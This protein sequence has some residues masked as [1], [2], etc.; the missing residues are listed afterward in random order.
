[1]YISNHVTRYAHHALN[2][3]PMTNITTLA[4]I[5]V[6]DLTTY[7]I[8]T[9]LSEYT[10]SWKSTPDNQM[11]AEYDT[12]ISENNEGAESADLKILLISEIWGVKT[13]EQDEAALFRN[14]I[15]STMSSNHF[16]CHS[17]DVICKVGLTEIFEY[18]DVDRI[19]DTKFS[20]SLGFFES[21]H[22]DLFLIYQ[23]DDYPEK[24]T[25]R[26]GQ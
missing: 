3:V 14:D 24:R 19:K 4:T 18:M 12:H 10:D 13:E 22:L 1:M 6:H 5:R 23:E 11:K 9:V 17:V 16:L 2:L 21:R 8:W 7:W 26:C 25:K 20:Y 15:Y